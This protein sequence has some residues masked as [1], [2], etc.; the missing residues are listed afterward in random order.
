MDEGVNDEVK[1]NQILDHFDILWPL[2]VEVGIHLWEKGFFYIEL[3]FTVFKGRIPFF[4]LNNQVNLRIW[5]EFLSKTLIKTKR[6]HMFVELRIILRYFARS[7][8]P[9]V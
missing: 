1:R 7:F 8:L 2:D 6:S 4:F 3:S 9:L 5:W